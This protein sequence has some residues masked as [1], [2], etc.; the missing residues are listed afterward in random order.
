LTIYCENPE[1]DSYEIH[2][3]IGRLVMRL[4]RTEFRQQLSISHLSP[5]IFVILGIDKDNQIQLEKR[6]V[7]N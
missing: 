6:W 5:G 7:K 3:A 1:V 2:D 4:D